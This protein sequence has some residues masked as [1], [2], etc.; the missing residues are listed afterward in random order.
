MKKLAIVGSHSATR[1]LAP[2]NDPDYEIWVVN[3]A[4]QSDWCLRWD[5][6]FQLHLE[7]V[8]TGYNHVKTDHWDWLQ[9]DHGDKVIWMQEY[10]ARVPNCHVYPLDE[11]KRATP[12]EMLTSSVAMM[13]ALA[14]MQRHEVIEVWGVELTSNSEY[15][16]Q[17]EGWVYWV[18]FAR[19]V[20]FESKGKINLILHSGID[21]H[22]TNRTY[23]YEGDPIMT[24][25]FKARGEILENN[26]GPNQKRLQ[27]VD[28]EIA[29]LLLKFKFQEVA[30]ALQEMETAAIECGMVA[31]ALGEAMY[32][33]S[34]N[35]Q[36][37]P[38]QEI[39]RRA[40]KAQSDGEDLKAKMFHTGGKLEY[41]WNVWAQSGRYEA[42]QQLR[43]L[44][45][46]KRQLAYDMGARLGIYRDNM[47]YLQE[48]DERVR[49]MGG[50]RALEQI[51]GLNV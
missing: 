4:P 3:E 7:K 12:D 8:Y 41:V 14:I 46:D 39:E 19:G 9:Q 6:D 32:Y 31:G 40:A 24:D 34:R 47:A 33:S 5:V 11:I 37:T 25:H 45:K 16:Y 26:L 50:V 2:W 43:E 49:A 48:Y 18:G 29:E 22:F 36:F 1:H 23:G 28:D 42:L 20:A 13:L 35:G 30:T 10:D 17:V 27:R 44:I 38:R 15:A 51:G 21:E